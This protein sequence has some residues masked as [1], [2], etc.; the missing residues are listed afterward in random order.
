MSKSTIF[1][2]YAAVFRF[3]AFLVIQPTDNIAH[4]PFFNVFRVFIA[5]VF[6]GAA[7]GQASAFA[8]NLAKAKLSANRIFFTL[9]RQPKIDNYSEE[10]ERPVSVVITRDNPF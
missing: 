1:F 2:L 4:V 6:G 5:I 9:D 3:G 7:I 10:G 8:P